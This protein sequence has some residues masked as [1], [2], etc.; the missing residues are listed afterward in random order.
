MAL[1]AAG[2]AA[3]ETRGVVA[4]RDDREALCEWECEWEGAFQAEGVAVVAIKK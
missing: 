3:V 4:G 2:V 1:A